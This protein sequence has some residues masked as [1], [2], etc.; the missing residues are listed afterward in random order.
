[1]PAK[2]WPDWSGETCVIVGAGPSARITP[3]EDVSGKARVIAINNSWKLCPWAD[4]LYATDYRWWASNH[5]VPF[6]GLKVSGDRRSTKFEGVK[7]VHVRRGSDE[8]V[9]TPQGV[10]AWGGNSGMQA[11]NLAVQWGCQKIILTGI[12]ATVEHGTHWHGDH[13]DMGNPNSGTVRRWRRAIDAAAPVIAGL[14]VS[15]INVSP[16]S[17][18]EAYPKMTFKE[19]LAA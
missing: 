3:L 13:P 8:F 11:L 10:V 15:V 9:V 4:V 7:L 16:I 5:D 2:W 19:A 14:G 6:R 1:M 12:D 17:T 18:L